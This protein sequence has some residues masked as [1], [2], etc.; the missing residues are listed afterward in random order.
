M[1][2]RFFKFRWIDGHFHPAVS[3]PEREY[4]VGW[5]QCLVQS[6]RGPAM[7][8]ELMSMFSKRHIWEFHR[9]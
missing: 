2:P 5:G 4:L 9:E 7:G 6:L 8:Q 1:L 3:Q